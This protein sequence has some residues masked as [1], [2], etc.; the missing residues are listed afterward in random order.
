MTPRRLPILLIAVTIVSGC[1]SNGAEPA[2]STRDT[3]TPTETTTT[4]AVPTT[5]TT[6][7][8]VPSPSGGEPLPTLD[9]G[10]PSTWVG[11]TADYEAVEV[12]TASGDVIR[13]LG[14]V[15]TAEDVETAECAACVNAIDA[16]WRTYDG[17]HILISECCEPAAGLIHVL[18][19][20]EIPLLPAG[21]REP[22][23]FWF[24]TPAPDSLRVAFLGYQLLLT[25]IDDPTRDVIEVLDRFP[26]SNAVWTA[27][28]ETVQWLEDDGGSVHLRTFEVLTATSTSV[29]LGA[30]DGWNLAGLARRA[31]GE[32]V[33][34]RPQPDGVATSVLVF[35]PG[36]ELVEEIPIEAGARLGGYDRSGTFLIYTAD[37]GAVRWMGD[38]DGGVLADGYVHASW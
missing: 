36:G 10:R 27:G 28:G 35:T 13:S 19:E 1:S 38:G 3:T 31:T 30:L 22:W 24:A 12:D 23:F 4:T 16:V 25:S 6:T 20:D 9:D 26:I 21:D 32:L 8:I 33:V 17:S 15:S 11:V 7:T 18:T 5:T 34:A 2:T 14:Q 37:D 29:P